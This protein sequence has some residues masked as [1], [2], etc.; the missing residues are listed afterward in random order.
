MKTI[1]KIKSFEIIKSDYWPD[2][3]LKITLKPSFRCN[4]KCWFCTEYS[5]NTKTWTLE[6]CNEVLLKLKLVWVCKNNSLSGNIL[7]IL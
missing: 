1:D 4:H 5:N 6:Q 2:Y 7:T 3:D